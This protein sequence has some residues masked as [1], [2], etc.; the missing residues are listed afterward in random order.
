[1]FNKKLFASSV[2]LVALS[3]P[4]AA[5]ALPPTS[6]PYFAPTNCQPNC[7]DFT[8]YTQQNAITQS[9]TPSSLGY[10]EGFLAYDASTVSG[11]NVNATLTNLYFTSTGIG[12]AGATTSTWAP[13]VNLNLPVPNSSGTGGIGGIAGGSALLS[14]SGPN[15]GYVDS[16]TA[17]Y[18]TAGGTSYK[19]NL[20]ANS[21]NS[22]IQ[23]YQ[24]RS[25]ANIPSID[26]NGYG[27]TDATRNTI[28]NAGVFGGQIA[29]EM[30]AASAFNV[31]ALLG[32]LALI[33]S[34]RKSFSIE[35]QRSAVSIA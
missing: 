23:T 25:W 12:I 15:A 35:S 14:I 6:L 21:S 20:L 26:Q 5:N 4:G 18:F 34:R 33:Y 10:V 11:G 9:S 27:N 22:S 17:I 32:C 7:W 3:L 29:P 1:M 8:I 2:A 16:N 30:D 13:I 31:F 19:V 28:L 24:G